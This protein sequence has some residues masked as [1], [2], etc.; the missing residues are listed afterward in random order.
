MQQTHAADVAD[1]CSPRAGRRRAAQGWAGAAAL[2]GLAIGAALLVLVAAGG[3]DL[4][5]PA[6]LGFGRIVASDRF[7]KS[8]TE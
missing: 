5:L 3:L 4:L 1:P 6:G 8:G 2:Q 7:R